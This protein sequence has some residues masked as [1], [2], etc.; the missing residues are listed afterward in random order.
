MTNCDLKV[1]GDKLVITVNLEE[2]HGPSKTGKTTI[3]G[4]TH[5]FTTV[6]YQGEPISVSVNV[7]KRRQA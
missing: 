1:N 2:T 6:D 7:T 5:G 3:V 4:T